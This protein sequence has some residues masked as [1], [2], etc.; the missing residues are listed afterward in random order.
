MKKTIKAKYIL[1]I[2]FLI[3]ICFLFI[4]NMQSVFRIAKTEVLAVFDKNESGFL[5]PVEIESA[6]DENF[7]EKMSFINLNGLAH[8]FMGQR[9]MNGTIKGSNGKLFLDSDVEFELDKTVEDNNINDALSIMA[10]AKSEGAEILYVQRPMK[11]IEGKDKLPYGMNVEYNLQYDYW[12]EKISEKGVNVVDLRKE[13]RKDLSF[14]KTDHHWTLESSFI[15]A[16]KIMDSISECSDNRIIYDKALFDHKN[17][18]LEEHRNAFLGSEGVKTGEYYAGK[19][20]FNILKPLFE[21][22]LSY[23]HYIENKCVVDKA[24]D[25]S[26]A[27]L[28]KQILQDEEYYNKYNACIYGGYVENIIKNNNRGNGKK[29]LLISDSFARP[30]VMYLSLAFE[31]TRYLDPQEGRYNDSY[32]DYIKD[33]KPDVVVMM[34]TGSFVEA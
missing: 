12:C 11:Y 32:I 19:D 33:Y 28:D 6:Y 4:A 23:K 17:Y 7:Y 8:R 15:A 2:L 9:L 5:A 10:A 3:T 16:G 25:F 1:T 14:Y 31:E 24:G 34:Y 21:T 20:D 27:F 29:L 22:N 18:A 13:M 30:M 26:E